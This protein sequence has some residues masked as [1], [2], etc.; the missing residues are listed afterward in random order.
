VAASADRE[1]GDLAGSYYRVTR[2]RAVVTGG[3]CHLLAGG[4]NSAF[5]WS[6]SASSTDRSTSPVA[7]TSLEHPLVQ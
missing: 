1:A 3:G 7:V 5:I 2:R 6:R 4:F